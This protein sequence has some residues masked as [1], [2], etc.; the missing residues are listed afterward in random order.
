M[1]YFL[2]SDILGNHKIELQTSLVIDFK[3]T[4]ILLNYLNLENRINWG[5]LFYNNSVV[6]PYDVTTGSYNFFKDIGLNINFQ[7]PFSKFSR[8]EGGVAHNYLEENEETTDWIGNTNTDYVASIN[9]TRYYVKYVWDNT[10]FFGGNRTFVEYMSAPSTNS[11]DK[12]FDKIELDSRNY[13]NLSSSGYVTFASR[14]FFGTSWGRD[15]RIFGIGGSGY[16]TLFH[17]DDSLLNSDYGTANDYYQYVSMNNFQFPIRGYNIA[18]K[19]GNKALIAN[20]ELRLPFLIYYFP[21]IK[22]F[23]QIF[24]VLFIDA[25]VAWNDRFPDFSNRDNWELFDSNDDPINEGWIMSYGF[26]P[27][28]YFL[29]MPWKLDY[30]WQYNPHKGTVSSRKWYLSIGFDF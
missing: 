22:Y 17:G 15:A 12:V 24:G 3:H 7:N 11:N 2:F 9:L 27:R 19:F 10:Q 23:G 29:G 26:G 25:G 8:I 16:N 20:F 5:L 1:G 28:F 4:D 30:A 13:I 6:G 14:L 18:Q 21:T